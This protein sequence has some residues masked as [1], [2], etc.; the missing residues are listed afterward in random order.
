MFWWVN[1]DICKNKLYVAWFGG[2]CGTRQPTSCCCCFKRERESLKYC[3]VRER[4]MATAM[5]MGSQPHHHHHSL[6]FSSSIFNLS[7]TIHL[8]HLLTLLL[9]SPHLHKVPSFSIDLLPFH[10]YSSKWGYPLGNGIFYLLIPHLG[11]CI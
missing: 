5:K 6:W 9:F 8:P 4:K 10:L 11:F 2:F 7:G 1:N 3:E